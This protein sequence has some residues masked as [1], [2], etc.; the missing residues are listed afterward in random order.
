MGAW[1]NE[2]YATNSQDITKSD[3]T[4]LSGV[5]AVYVGGA[6]NLAVKFSGDTNAVTFTA[7]PVGTIIRGQFARVMNTNTTAT[8]L[9]GLS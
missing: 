7:V 4:D 6:G 1:R 5:M 8:L 9:V 2:F 3:S